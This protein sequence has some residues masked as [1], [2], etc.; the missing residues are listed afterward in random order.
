MCVVM[1]CNRN[2]KTQRFPRK[3]ASSEWRPVC[4]ASR[5]TT[6]FSS[7]SEPPEVRGQAKPLYATW[8]GLCSYRFGF[9][10]E[11][12]WQ[13]IMIFRAI[14]QEAG[15]GHGWPWNDTLFCDP[16]CTVE[17]FSFDWSHPV[18]LSK[19]SKRLFNLV[20]TQP[21]L[22]YQSINLVTCFTSLSH[23]QANSQTI[24]EVHSVDV[25]ILGSH[26]T[27]TYTFYCQ[28]IVNI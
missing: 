27:V 25:H 28:T 23:H 10:Q 16:V 18:V 1:T 4:T 20:R 9:L 17:N 11:R 13:N 21:I 3:I 22:H 7:S 15:S 12:P 6:A 19:S 14:W 5:V 26:R 8:N 2:S 24:L